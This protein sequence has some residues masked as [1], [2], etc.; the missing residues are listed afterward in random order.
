MAANYINLRQQ[1]WRER[2]RQRRAAETPEEKRLD[3]LK[4][5]RRR[6]KEA[7]ATERQQARVLKAQIN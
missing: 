7:G 5:Y 6:K 4:E 1:L 2:D 3:R